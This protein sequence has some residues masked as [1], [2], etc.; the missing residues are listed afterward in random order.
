MHSLTRPQGEA[1]LT[2]P[3]PTDAKGNPLAPRDAWGHDHCWWL[4]RMVRSDQPLAERMTLVWH[5]WFAT[6]VEGANPRLVLEQNAMLRRHALGNFRSL[7][8]DVT[9]D[10]AML[11]WLSGTK[12]SKSSP[13]ENYARELMELFTLGAGRG[14]TERDV[15]ELARAL[16]GFRNDWRDGVGPHN[17]RF[18]PA[19]H[20]E[21]R[22]RVFRKSG[23]HDWRDACELCLR[24]PKHPSFLVSKLWGYFIPTPPPKA[25]QRALERLYRDRRGAIRPLVEAILL[26]PDFHEGPRMVTPPVVHAAGLLRA[27]G[28]GVDTDAWSWL[29]D[30]AGQKLF[31]PPNVSG[32][33]DERWLDTSTWRGR[34]QTLNTILR[35]R[36]LNPSDKELVAAYPADE[37]AAEAVAKA[38]AFWG[39]PTVSEATREALL[40]FARRVEDGAD[41]K[42]KRQSYRVLRQNALR[43]LIA[44]SPDLQTS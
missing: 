42:W 38:L 28:R 8:R 22:K 43:H 16:T 13:N 2:G 24:H 20:D 19:H 34:W 6:S 3:A 23:R 15:R 44:T 9:S 18:D 40:A 12:N 36:E 21:G 11:L 41:Q 33:D 27:I 10:P 29:A 25:S 5:D 1:Q 32:W 17:F 31:R 7:L 4:D 14:Y 39:Q 26:H 30:L 37:T 35:D